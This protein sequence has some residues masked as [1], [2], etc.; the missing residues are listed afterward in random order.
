MPS[1]DLEAQLQSP[2]NLLR[3][4]ETDETQSPARGALPSNLEANLPSN[5]GA[6]LATSLDLGAI[7]RSAIS[8]ESRQHLGAISGAPPDLGAISEEVPPY[9][10][11]TSSVVSVDGASSL[12]SFLPGLTPG[13]RPKEAEVTLTLTLRMN[14]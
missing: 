11:G 14:P 12:G 1:Q 13:R 4:S 5:P 6:I 2:P 3:I 10:K 8:G 7:S 9:L